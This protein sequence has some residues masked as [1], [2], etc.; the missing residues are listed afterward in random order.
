VALAVLA[1]IG[2][3]AVN[4]L[5]REPRMLSIG[6]S[7]ALFGGV[8]VL[9]ALNGADIVRHQ[10]RFAPPAPYAGRKERGASLP[11]G[12]GSPPGFA[13]ALA[14]RLLPPLAAGMALLGILGGGGE[15]RT[16]Y[17]AHIWGFCCGL[18]AALAALPFEQ[19]LLALPS[20][21]QAA[22]QAGLFLLT[23]ALVCAAW[24]YALFR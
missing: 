22:G 1:G 12:F 2:G 14:K 10:R 6:F 3:N 11:G 4:A 19:R 23:L 21:Q 24:G 18:A 15:A 8:G 9:C 5:T 16:D 17:F 20:G 7:T 13:L